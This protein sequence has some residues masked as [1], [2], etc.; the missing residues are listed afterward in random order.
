[1]AVGAGEMV[2]L[3]GVQ[4][5]LVQNTLSRRAPS[6]AIRSMFGVWFTALP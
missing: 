4:I 6:W 3:D 1:M 2:A 5:E